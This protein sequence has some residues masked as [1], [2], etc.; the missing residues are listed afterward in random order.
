MINLKIENIV[1]EQE[2]NK[3]T[4]KKKTEKIEKMRI[5]LNDFP[6]ILID[7]Q[8]ELKKNEFEKLKKKVIGLKNLVRTTEKMQVRLNEQLNKQVKSMKL[9]NSEI[10]Q[11]IISKKEVYYMLFTYRIVIKI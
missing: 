5:K 7:P 10:E 1:H 2:R 6:E 8:E 3:I 9:N 4:S 11:Q